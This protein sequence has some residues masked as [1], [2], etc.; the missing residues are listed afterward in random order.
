MAD[1]PAFNLSVSEFI[2]VG[3]VIASIAVAFTFVRADVVMLKVDVGR[4]QEDVSNIKVSQA[5]INESQNEIKHTVDILLDRTTR[6][7][8]SQIEVGK[9]LE[10]VKR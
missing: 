2:A 7:T 4:L 10:A 1:R 9:T 8:S 5:K 3:A 6:V